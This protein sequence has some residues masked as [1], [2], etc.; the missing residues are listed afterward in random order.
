MKTVTILAP[1]RGWTKCP[2]NTETW[3]FGKMLF[4]K[5][6]KRID[7]LYL[8]D[9]VNK[10]AMYRLN[11]N[12]TPK[13]FKDLINKADVPLISVKKYKD[14]P[15]S[16]NFPLKKIVKRFG[17]NYFASSFAFMIAL[18]IYEGYDHIIFYGV[19]QN[20]FWERWEEKA[21]VEFWLGMAKARGIKV[22]IFG[23][24]SGL[25]VNPFK[26]PY[27]YTKNRGQRYSSIKKVV[28]SFIKDEDI[29]KRKGR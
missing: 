29:W 28:K 17:I 20:G 18:A 27:G 16:V 21:C 5:R 13:I 8:M 10:L 7:R 6:V 23:K 25:L 12:I 11:K 9:D 14:I 19:N 4:K 15:K 2:F 24:S 1:G 26:K 22:S 3:V